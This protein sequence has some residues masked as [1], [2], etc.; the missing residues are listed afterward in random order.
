MPLTALMPLVAALLGLV[1]GL[2]ARSFARAPG[3]EPFRS[4]APP[5]LWA[6]LYCLGDLVL[7]SPALEQHA[8]FW[9]PVQHVA[10]GGLLYSLAGYLAAVSGPRPLDRAIRVA[11]LAVACAGLLGF[12]PGLLFEARDHARDVAWLDAVYTEAEPTLVGALVL[13]ASLLC[14]LLPVVRVVLDVRDGRPEASRHALGFALL[15]LTGAVDV[16]T[17]SLQLPLPF[18]FSLGFA[19]T[20]F[21]GAQAVFSRWAA[22]AAA[23]DARSRDL[24]RLIEER[25]QE[26]TRAREQ[27]LET[28]KL[29][30]LGQLAAGVAHEVNNPAA[31]VVANLGYVLDAQARTGDFP[32]DAAAS[33]RESLTAMGRVTRIVRQLLDT[34]RAGARREVLGAVSLA[35]A[36]EGTLAIV[37]PLV[38]A[39]VTLHAAA[40]DSLAALA[41]EDLLVQCLVNLVTNAM[42]AIPEGRTGR[43][44]VRAEVIEGPAAT[45]GR[46]RLHVEDDGAGMSADIR[47]RMFEPFFTTKPPGIGT[48]LGLS[49]TLG[50]VRSMGGEVSID[51]EEGRGTRVTLDLQSTEPVPRVPSTAPSRSLPPATRLRVLLVDDERP[52]RNALERMLRRTYDVRLANG[53][54]EALAALEDDADV[55]FILCDV[56]MAEGGGERVYRTLAA[57]DPQL[58]ARVIFMTGGAHDTAREFLATQPQ[59]V[60]EKPLDTA[61][62]A[63]TIARLRGESA[64]APRLS[65]AELARQLTPDA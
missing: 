57:R 25:T 34:G 56:L 50:L 38:P 62:L 45:H 37:R 19:C 24:S 49:V 32:A 47:R 54:D 29:A 48:G 11:G 15:M 10:A 16:A 12:V 33:L 58:A 51:S 61:S 53:V 35:R 20:L 30:A 5:A 42:Q 2:I 41:R 13:A 65:L 27:L 7:A 14:L 26:L 43:V 21:I 52:V 63:S 9:S 60:L 31:A 44:T 17:I 55:D 1:A 3:W 46:V 8:T 40:D 23:L 22:H 6:S 39:H 64:P 59:P 36:V 18:L 4:V 28:E